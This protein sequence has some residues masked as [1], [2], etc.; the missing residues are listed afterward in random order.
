MYVSLYKQPNRIK[1][2][3]LIV[4]HLSIACLIYFFMV[5][6][7]HQ[8]IS[9]FKNLSLRKQ[10]REHAEISLSSTYRK[11]LSTPTE[12]SQLIRD[13]SQISHRCGLTHFK[14]IPLPQ[15]KIDHTLIRKFHIILQ[16]KFEHILKFLVTVL[17]LS[18]P[19]QFT[20]WNLTKNEETI[21]LQVT[22]ALYSF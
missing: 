15:S 22:I 17:K 10:E 18:Y 13:I 20:Q 3:G 6:P 2:I 16:G 1:A 19:L 8:K 5:I 21:I 14:Y 4:S 12:M 7:L 11:L 9:T